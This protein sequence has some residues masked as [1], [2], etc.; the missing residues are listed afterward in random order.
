MRK[1]TRPES[2]TMKAEQWTK[3]RKWNKL[4]GCMPTPNEWYSK[5]NY[6]NDTSHMWAAHPHM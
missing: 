3:D 4:Q 6:L 2:W 5:S 1:W